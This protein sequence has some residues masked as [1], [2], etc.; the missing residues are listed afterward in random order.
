M[1]AAIGVHTVGAIFMI[2]G[3]CD[4]TNIENQP[5]PRVWVNFSIENGCPGDE[6]RE[7]QRRTEVQAVATKRRQDGCGPGAAVPGYEVSH[8]GTWNAG[9]NQEGIA[10]GAAPRCPALDS[11]LSISCQILADFSPISVSNIDFSV[12]VFKKC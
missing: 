5:Q 9:G 1:I 7:N 3:L 2:K 8:E 10:A 11:I 6:E 12:L 4:V